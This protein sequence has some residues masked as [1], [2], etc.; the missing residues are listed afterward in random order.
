MKS[1]IHEHAMYVFWWLVSFTWR[2]ALEVCSCCSRISLLFKSLN[3][4]PLCG[5]DTFCLVIHQLIGLWIVLTLRL[6]WITQ[7]WTYMYMFLCWHV[8]S[9]LFGIYLRVKFLGHVVNLIFNILR[10][11]QTV[12][13]NGWSILHL[14]NNVRDWH[15]SLCIFLLF[16][17][18]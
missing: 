10:S 1:F 3:T 6:L 18:S 11:F 16:M 7:V 2:D 17:G 5:W 8:F 9:F 12:F 15:L 14:H 4:I 13:Q